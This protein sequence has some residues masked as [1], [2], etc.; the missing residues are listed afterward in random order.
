MAVVDDAQCVLVVTGIV[1]NQ[2]CIDG[3][4]THFGIGAYKVERRTDRLA[5][6]GCEEPVGNDAGRIIAVGIG[7]DGEGDGVG[8]DGD[9]LL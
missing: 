9:D 7:R 3:E 4:E 6:G 2:T 1:L 5:L 8:A